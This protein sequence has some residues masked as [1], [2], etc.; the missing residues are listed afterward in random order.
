MRSPFSWSAIERGPALF[1]LLFLILAW[2]YTHRI[3]THQNFVKF[4]A[5]RAPTH[6]RDMLAMLLTDRRAKKLEVH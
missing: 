6:D 4:R 3:S 2:A 5:C 1:L